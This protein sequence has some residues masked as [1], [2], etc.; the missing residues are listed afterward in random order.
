MHAT[1]RRYE[2]VDTNRTDELSKKVAESLA[3]SP[4]EQASRLRGLLLDRGRPRRLQLVRAVRDGRAGCRV[5][6]GRSRLVRDEKLETV[7]PNAPEITSGEVI[8]RQSG[9]TPGIGADA[10]IGSGAAAPHRLA[11]RIIMRGHSPSA[12]YKVR[13][14]RNGLEQ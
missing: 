8:A 13:P 3:R 9:V 6:S 10:V 12:P 14:E 2:G 4:A 7:L 5:D 11:Q 1:I